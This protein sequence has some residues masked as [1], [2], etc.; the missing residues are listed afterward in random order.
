MNETIAM[1]ASSAG[2]VGITNLA[3]QTGT[4][5]TIIGGAV[6]LGVLMGSIVAMHSINRKGWL[7]WAIRWLVSNIGENVVY[8]IGTCTTL[9]SIYF[10]GSELSKFGETNPNFLSD[11]AFLFGELIVAVAALALIGWVSKPIWNWL[12]A[13]ASSE[14]KRKVKTC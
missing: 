6:V 9:Y 12:V 8:G 1:N 5:G 4:I 3:T 2:L 13:Y 10:V 11:M 7:Y 14:K